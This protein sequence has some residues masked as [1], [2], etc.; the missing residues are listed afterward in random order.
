MVLNEYLKLQQK[1]TTKVIS[2]NIWYHIFVI[3][4]ELNRNFIY[5]FVLSSD[6]EERNK[7]HISFATEI[8][9]FTE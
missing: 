4:G 9:R 8:P 3:I 5:L 1:K 7:K 6:K 2:Y